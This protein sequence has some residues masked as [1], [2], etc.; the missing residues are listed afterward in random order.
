MGAAIA[1]LRQVV[2]AYQYLNIAAS[3]PAMTDIRSI[4][5]TALTKK[6]KKQLRKQTNKQR[7]GTEM[8]EAQRRKYPT[9]KKLCLACGVSHPL[10]YFSSR[11]SSAAGLSES[12]MRSK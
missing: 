6:A 2:A 9:G 12:C 1:K 3:S 11:P 5:V 8:L 7:T 10:V 4:E